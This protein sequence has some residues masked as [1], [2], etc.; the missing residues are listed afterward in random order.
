ME[1]ETIRILGLSFLNGSARDAVERV[2]NTGGVLTVP[3]APA[4]VRLRQDPIYRQAMLSADY[5]IPDSGLMVLAWR[6]LRGEKLTRVSG[7]VYLRELVS[8]P[9]FREGGAAFFV[10]PSEEARRKLL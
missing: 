9:E 4:L 2:S 7:L 6:I 8:R 1:S 5:A 3:A 10:L